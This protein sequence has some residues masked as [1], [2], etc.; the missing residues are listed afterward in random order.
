[1]KKLLITSTLVGSL[2]SSV[3]M[4]KTEGL[5]LGI[6]AL[7]TRY[8]A[9]VGDGTIITE[10]NQDDVSAGV[11]GNIKFAI[12]MG[13]FFIAP[14]AFFNYNNASVSETY[15][16][17]N[18]KIREELEYSYGG[19]ADIGFDITDKFAVFGTIGYQK[20]EHEREVTIL[21]DKDRS[22]FES[23]ALIYGG[24]LKV[25]VSDHVDLSVAYE[26]VD[27]NGDEDD[28]DVGADS[29]NPQVAKVGVAFKF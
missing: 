13:G 9:N 11:G 18:V 1:M 14:G 26:Y 27:Y 3:A 16:S 6:D 19:K 17:D 29:N 12:N 8:E 21:G 24:G 20:N 23:D 25:S 7:A 10:N 5:Y 2:I 4:A 15:V 28:N 22:N